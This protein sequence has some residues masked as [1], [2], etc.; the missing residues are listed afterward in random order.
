MGIWRC[1][2]NCLH[3]YIYLPENGCN[4]K[5]QNLISGVWTV[6]GGRDGEYTSATVGGMDTHMPLCMR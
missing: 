3:I 4:Q 5:Y 1:G 6:G 2:V